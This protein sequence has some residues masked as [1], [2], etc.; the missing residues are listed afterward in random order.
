M[1]VLEIR[2]QNKTL[3]VVN[4]LL[5]AKGTTLFYDTCDDNVEDGAFFDA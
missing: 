3:K 1:E 5:F 4:T 2:K